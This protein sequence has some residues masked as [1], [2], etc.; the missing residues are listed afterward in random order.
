MNREATLA[1]ANEVLIRQ[2]LDILR[3]VESEVVTQIE[4]NGVEAKA[5]VNTGITRISFIMIWI[6]S[7]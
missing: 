6:F 4:Q 1:S 3:K 7:C 2:M 5:V